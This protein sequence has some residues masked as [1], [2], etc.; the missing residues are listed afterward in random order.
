MEVVRSF[1]RRHDGDVVWK[2]GI[3]RVGRAL[4]RRTAVHAHARD[5]PERMHASVGA[6]RDREAVPTGKTASNASRM[7]P[8]TVR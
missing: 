4:G 3:E 6:A 7:T 2:G 8:S 5:L 1:L